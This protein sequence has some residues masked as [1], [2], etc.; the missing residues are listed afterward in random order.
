MATE[1][2]EPF[3]KGA[4]KPATCTCDKCDLAFQHTSGHDFILSVK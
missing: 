1:G 3:G 2:C 4:A